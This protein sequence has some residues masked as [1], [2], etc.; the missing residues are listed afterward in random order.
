MFFPIGYDDNGLPTERLVEKRRNIRAANMPREEFVKNC[1][2]V[3]QEV[4]K[5][6][7]ALFGRLGM[8]YD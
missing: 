4:R 3:V 1:L 7:R 8:S 2:E 5:D 6:F